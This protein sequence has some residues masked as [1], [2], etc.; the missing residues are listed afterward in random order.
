MK[1]FA[2]NEQETNRLNMLATWINEQTIREIYLKPFQTAVV[3]GGAQAAMS[4]LNY[5]GTT[6]AG[7]Y[8]PLMK[9]V[10]RGEWGFRGMVLTDYFGVYGYQNADQL[11]RNGNDAMLATTDVTNHVKDKSAT[12][13]KAMRQASHNI[14][15][16]VVHGYKYANGDPKVQT[17][18]WQIALYVALVVLALIFLAL[19][20]LAFRRF[21]ARRSAVN[22][23][24]LSDLAD[25]AR[26]TRAQD[27]ASMESTPSENSSDQGPTA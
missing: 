12:S 17:P 20:Y 9:D 1:H 26:Q 18:A 21:K 13:V 7:A 14:L 5:I 10:L 8:A 22:V 23:G 11:I 16:T 15:Y 3:K 25:D 19:E 2:L 27:P 4:S 6:Y 24:T